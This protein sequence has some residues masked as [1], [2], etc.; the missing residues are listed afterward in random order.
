MRTKKL[1][2]DF[3]YI[4]EMSNDDYY[5]PFLVDKLKGVFKETVGQLEKGNLSNSDIQ[6]L[7]DKMIVKTNVLQEEFEEND[8]E[9]DTVARESIG[10]TIDKVLR[11]FEISMN[12]E[13]A[14]RER[15]W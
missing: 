12:I 2:E 7:F 5:P 14:L 4:P 11:Y 1:P 13:E 15:D 10:M 8:S 6:E 3:E 9:F